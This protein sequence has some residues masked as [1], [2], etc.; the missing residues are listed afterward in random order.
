MMETEKNNEKTTQT[1]DKQK[2]NVYKK[3]C[4]KKK[5]DKRKIRKTTTSTPKG[6]H[7][8]DKKYKRNNVNKRQSI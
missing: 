5:T 3:I 1:R 4:R 2:T 8:R 6:M 7:K